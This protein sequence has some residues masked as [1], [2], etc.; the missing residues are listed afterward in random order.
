MSAIVHD[1][2]VDELYKKKSLSA[3]I[4]LIKAGRELEFEYFGE[5][6]FVSR[7]KSKGNVSIY[8]GDEEEFF[9]SEEQLIEKTV[10]QNHSFLSVWN[11]V[12]LGTLF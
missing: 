12:K 10:L 7:D 11:D 8:H 4:Y 1:L 9:D 2:V 3:F 6:Y 5:Q